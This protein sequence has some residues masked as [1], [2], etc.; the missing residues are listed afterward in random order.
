MSYTVPEVIDENM[1]RSQCTRYHGSWE[2]EGALREWDKGFRL[3][4]DD[5]PDVK[6]WKKCTTW[7]G[8]ELTISDMG[9]N[10]KRGVERGRSTACEDGGGP[11]VAEAEHACWGD[12][13]ERTEEGQWGLTTDGTVS[14]VGFFLVCNFWCWMKLAFHLKAFP[15]TLHS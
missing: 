15:H 6:S 9:S 10:R 13:G 8:E 14:W 4:E 5:F 7:T 1:I 2:H 12:W 3:W 11:D